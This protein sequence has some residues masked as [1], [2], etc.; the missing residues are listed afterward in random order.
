MLSEYAPNTFTTG[1]YV[2]LIVAMDHYHIADAEGVII[3]RLGELYSLADQT[4]F[5]ARLET[6]GTPVLE[7]AFARVKLS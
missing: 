3:Q 4:G 7:E 5:I 6:D 2:G 1:L